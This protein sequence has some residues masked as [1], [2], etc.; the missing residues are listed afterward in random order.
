MMHTTRVGGKY[1]IP[2]PRQGREVWRLERCGTFCPK[3]LI[4]ACGPMAELWHPMMGILFQAVSQ[5][6]MAVNKPNRVTLP[7]SVQGG[8]PVSL[9]PHGSRIAESAYHPCPYCDQLQLYNWRIYP[10]FGNPIRFNFPYYA[11]L[12]IDAQ[13]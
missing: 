1:R 13:F 11:L 4:F 5:P 6:E 7:S 3:L 8:R 9:E 12:T 10:I 2:G